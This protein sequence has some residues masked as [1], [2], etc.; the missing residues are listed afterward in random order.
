[1]HP[2]EL[3][4]AYVDGS[5]SSEEREAVE[6][7]LATC[8]TCREEM[9]LARTA[10]LALASLPEVD[11]PGVARAGLAGLL[12]TAPGVAPEHRV[13]LDRKASEGAA[14]EAPTKLRPE[15]RVAWAPVLAAAAIVVIAGLITLPF[16]LRGGGGQAALAPSRAAPTHRAAEAHL[17]ALVDRGSSYTPATVHSLAERLL[18]A[19]KVGASA[20]RSGTSP[21]PSQATLGAP[22]PTGAGKTATGTEEIAESREAL[23]CL[24]MGN[25]LEPDASPIYL[26]Q[27]TFKGVP[28][29]VGAFTRTGVR[30]N[31]VVVV[32]SRTTCQPLYTLTQSV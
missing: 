24:I 27:A 21:S 5:A 23:D 8:R 28:A 3:L 18:P 10:H 20:D 1:M 4:A 7:H 32:V 30:L 17:P 16:L 9:A 19:A 29:Y 14:P 25:G 11:P 12:R 22:A 15:R 26:E 31:F 6:A 2:D 13:E